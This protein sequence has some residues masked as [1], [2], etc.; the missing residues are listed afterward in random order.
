MNFLVWF[1]NRNTN[2]GLYCI[3]AASNIYKWLNRQ[4][5]YGFIWIDLYTIKNKLYLG[6][7]V[8]FLSAINHKLKYL[9]RAAKKSGHTFPLWKG[10]RC[11]FFFSFLNTLVKYKKEESLTNNQ[12][13]KQMP[14]FIL[15]EKGGLSYNTMELMII[16]LSFLVWHIFFLS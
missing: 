7:T 14:F 5:I 2:W 13:N 4:P 16:G 11:V 1:W 8:P 15:T 10:E 3:T 9:M 6:L 12:T